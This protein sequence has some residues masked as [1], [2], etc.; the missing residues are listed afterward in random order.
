MRILIDIFSDIKKELT[1]SSWILYYDNIKLFL[2]FKVIPLKRTN[3]GFLFKLC[4]LELNKN[5][6]VFMLVK[7]LSGIEYTSF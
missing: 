1:I 5:V 4:L 6:G 2:R 3:N 7:E